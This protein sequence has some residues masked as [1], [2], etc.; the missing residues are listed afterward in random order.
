MTNRKEGL[1]KELKKERKG[2]IEKERKE[3]EDDVEWKNNNE[4]KTVNSI[5]FFLNACI[6]VC[7]CMQYSI[8]N[9]DKQINE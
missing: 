2:E 8:I 5:I 4:Y 9:T 1:N 6:F 3:K 7:F